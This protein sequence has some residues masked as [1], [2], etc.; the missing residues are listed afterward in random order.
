MNSL[1]RY[2]GQSLLCALLVVGSQARAE[3]VDI[4]SYSIDT[5]ISVLSDIRTRGT[6]DSLSTP[7]A[8][9]TVEAAHDSGLIAL[10]QIN[11]VS[12]KVMTNGDGAGILVAGGWRHGNPDNWHFGVGLAMEIFPGAQFDAPQS[13][14][15]QNGVPADVRGTSFN[16][17]YAVLE[18]GYGDIQGRVVNVISKTYRGANTGGVCGSMLQFSA[19]PTKALEC[20]ARGEHNSRG[21]WLFDL[22]YKYALRSDTTLKLHAGY[23][24]VA[25]FPEANLFD[26]SVGLAYV[27][28]KIDW[29]AALTGAIVKTREL[30][31]VQDGDSVKRTNRPTLVVSATYRF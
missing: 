22:D 26:Y 31:L 21:T 13:F 4:A 2:V 24:A 6:S 3:D 30:Y 19:D 28:W 17:Q 23:Q 27:K 16:T 29:E 8:R 7:G 1:S 20:Y 15:F 14:D 11:N 25:N 12:K 10:A 5:S 9:L 18:L